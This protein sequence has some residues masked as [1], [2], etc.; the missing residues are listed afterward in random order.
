MPICLRAVGAME[1]FGV[2][3]W[4]LLS[5]H[6]GPLIWRC[7]KLVW[8]HQNFGFPPLDIPVSISGQTACACD[9]VYKQRLFKTFTVKSVHL[10]A[11]GKPALLA[12]KCHSRM[13][14]K[15]L[16]KTNGCRCNHS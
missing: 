3:H 8:A 11:L 1:L 10:A 14:P 15:V 12:F 7:T 5:S 2:L 9:A 13:L 6:L 16:P 4:M